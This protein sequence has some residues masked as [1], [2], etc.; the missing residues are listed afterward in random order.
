MKL[1]SRTTGAVLGL[2]AIWAFSIAL[3]ASAANVAEWGVFGDSLSHD[4]Q[5]DFT[6]PDFPDAQIMVDMESE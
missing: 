3:P 2:A 4:A 5:V 1:A 6:N